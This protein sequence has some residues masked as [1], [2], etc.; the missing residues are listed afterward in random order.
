[1]LCRNKVADFAKW[2][3]VFDSHRDDHLKAGLTLEHVWPVVDDANNVFFVFWVD[4][5]EKA[6]AFINAPGAEEA[7]RESGVI[8]GEYHFVEDTSCY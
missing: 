8:D 6:K 4:D 3:Q 2:K 5:I 7:G 1:M